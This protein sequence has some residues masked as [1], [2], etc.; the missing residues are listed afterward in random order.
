MCV[1]VFICRHRKKSIF[2]HYYCEKA[3]IIF[4]LAITGAALLVH[5]LQLDLG[6]TVRTSLDKRTC[7]AGPF[8]KRM[9]VDMDDDVAHFLNSLKI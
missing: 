7:F 2:L 3:V 5:P 6:C 8:Q 4:R 9:K 1:L